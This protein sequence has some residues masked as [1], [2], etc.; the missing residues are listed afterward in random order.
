MYKHQP[1][2]TRRSIRLLRLQASASVD[3]DL[4]CDLDVVSLDDDCPKYA[5]LSYSWDAETPSRPLEC[6][7]GASLGLLDV[8]PNCAAALRQLRHPA[9]EVT[10]WIDSICIDQSSVSERNEQVALMADIYR[11]ANK[12]I[13]WLGEGSEATDRAINLLKQIGDVSLLHSE[14][15]DQFTGPQFQARR[16]ATRDR[17]HDNARRLTECKYFGRGTL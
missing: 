8:T 15:T 14:E 1:L 4:I 2:P 9:D 10:L 3:N 7:T 6:R 13:V 12:V 5:A 16:Q 11:D 17:L